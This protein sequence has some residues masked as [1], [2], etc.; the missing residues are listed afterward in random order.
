MK[1]Q[2]AKE[3]IERYRQAFSAPYQADETAEY[4]RLFKEI[5]EIAEHE[6]EERLRAKAIEAFKELCF[7]RDEDRCSISYGV[8]NNGNY[9][10]GKTCDE[11]CVHCG[12]LKN[13][14]QKLSEE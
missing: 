9:D 8:D 7:Q 10:A 11:Y 2:N 6:A 12:I 13:F 1:S 5:A 4:C 3:A 14:I